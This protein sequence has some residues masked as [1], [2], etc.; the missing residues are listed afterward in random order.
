MAI[1][2]GRRLSLGNSGGPRDVEALLAQKSWLSLWKS[3]NHS[4]KVNCMSP[5]VIRNDFAALVLI[6]HMLCIDGIV[7]V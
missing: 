2:K 4:P 7:R 6:I 5:H 3:H 1:T